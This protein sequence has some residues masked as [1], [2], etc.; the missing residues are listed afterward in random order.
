[1]GSLSRREFLRVGGGAFAGAFVLAG[2]GGAGGGGGGAFEP[3]RNVV[4]VIPF[5]PGGGSDILGRAM[6]AG[7]E[8][9]RPDANI[10]T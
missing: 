6:A 2:C 4:M 9:V 10:R 8:E 1:M 5:E 3:S 7:L